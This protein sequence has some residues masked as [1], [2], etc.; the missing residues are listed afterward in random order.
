MSK[1]GRPFLPSAGILAVFVFFTCG[2]SRRGGPGAAPVGAASPLR[3][4][5]LPLFLLPSPGSPLAGKP[6]SLELRAG[7]NPPGRF[8]PFDSLEVDDLFARQGG[9]QWILDPGGEGTFRAP[10]E[11]LLALLS[12]PVAV[13]GV[14]GRVVYCAKTIVEV[15]PSPGGKARPVPSSAAAMAGF[16]LEIVPMADP[17]ELGPGDDCPLQVLFQGVPLAGAPVRVV[18]EDGRGR[19]PLLLQTDPGGGICFRLDRD[20]GFLVTVQKEGEGEGRGKRT[21]V[22]TL[23]FRVKGGAR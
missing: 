7:W 8:T 3:A 18:G 12:R 17:G 6:F 16:P 10:G 1:Y 2:R 4:G 11:A 5:P 14:E 13:P 20:G 22:A 19:P 21:W 23:L 15:F 9:E